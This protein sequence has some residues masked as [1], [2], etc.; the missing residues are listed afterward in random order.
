[1]NALTRYHISGQVGS[2]NGMALRLLAECVAF[3]LPV[4]AC[5]AGGWRSSEGDGGGAA[6][7]LWL[8]PLAAS[9]WLVAEP[10][11]KKGMGALAAAACSA[12]SP[13]CVRAPWKLAWYC[14]GLELVGGWAGEWPARQPPVAGGWFAGRANCAG[15]PAGRNS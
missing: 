15:R 3:P 8:A 5:G 9:S 4:W 11:R 12:T 14:A 2:L 1:M 6:W 10:C 7:R 13:A